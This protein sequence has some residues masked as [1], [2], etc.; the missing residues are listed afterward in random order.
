M[1]GRNVYTMLPLELLDWL[2]PY[3]RRLASEIRE[4]RPDHEKRLTAL[5]DYTEGK[6]IDDLLVL[7]PIP[8]AVPSL[9]ADLILEGPTDI[10]VGMPDYT[11]ELNGSLV[12]ATR[13]LTRAIMASEG[14]A[15]DDNVA[16]LLR[17][18]R[19]TLSHLW[20]LGARAKMEAVAEEQ[21]VAPAIFKS[22]DW[23]FDPTTI[24]GHR[25][26]SELTT[27]DPDQIRAQVEVAKHWILENVDRAVVETAQG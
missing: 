5:I 26:F 17:L 11:D 1:P 16:K 6:T 15:E 27:P 21:G 23:G 22:T 12:L 13:A 10:V 4:L 20:P 19:R 18:F 8:S 25:P 14:D 24:R 2:L 7:L 3:I 9:S